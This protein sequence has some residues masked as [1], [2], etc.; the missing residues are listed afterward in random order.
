M[1]SSID[2]AWLFETK[3]N[4]RLSTQKCIKFLWARAAENRIARGD[5]ITTDA[6]VMVAKNDIGQ[7]L[8]GYYLSRLAH[9]EQSADT[10]KFAA[11]T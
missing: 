8:T 4:A 1:V 10:L 7:T 3:I 11:W 2:K 6:A 5:T 9:P